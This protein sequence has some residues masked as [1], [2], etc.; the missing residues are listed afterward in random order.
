MPC[1]FSSVF[2]D[3]CPTTALLHQ[4]LKSSNR[5]GNRFPEGN[6]HHISFIGASK[7]RIDYVDTK[8]MSQRSF[9]FAENCFAIVLSEP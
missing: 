8:D 4:F 9:A 2:F 5:P 3:L 7:R 6:Y 1:L